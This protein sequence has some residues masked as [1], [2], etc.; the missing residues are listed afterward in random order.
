VTVVDDSYNAN[1][2]S[3][4]AAVASLRTAGVVGKRVLVLGEMRELGDYAEEGHRRVGR[5]CADIDMLIGLGALVGPALEEAA[6]RGVEVYRA[7]SHEDAARL[8]GEILEPGDAVLFKGSRA[9]TVDRVLQLWED[10][11][12]AQQIT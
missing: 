6:S 9:V 10:G 7:E 4:E 11:L 2:A 1:P 12:R 5:A 8:L 3:V